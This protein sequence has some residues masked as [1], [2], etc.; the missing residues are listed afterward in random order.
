MLLAIVKNRYEESANLLAVA[1]VTANVSVTTSAGLQLG[2]G[3]ND[4]YAG[5][6][7]PFTA[8]VV[9]EENPTISYVPV[10]GVKYAQ[11]VFSPVPVSIL[12]RLTGSLADPTYVYNA[13]VSSVN[14]I[15]NPDFRFFPSDPD[16]HF[17]HFVALMTTLTQAQR[18]HWAEDPQQAASLAI[19]IDRY[20]PAHT[21]EVGELLNLLG[22]PKPKTRSARI[23]LPVY[24]ALDGRDS[25]GVGII[26]RSVGDLVEILSAAIEVPEGDQQKGIAKTYPPPAGAGSELSVRHSKTK[27]LHASVAVQYRDGW[28]YIDETDQA[29]KRFFRM[30]GALWSV[31]IADS[32][33]ETT[34]VPALT[35][36]VS[37]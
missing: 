4:N 33:S 23:A 17:S 32:A 31:T 5:N 20:A 8:G 21:V 11:Q 10:A 26:T 16:P 6:L 15:L 24:L 14:G 27:P 37:R 36:P 34:A 1:S 35:V 3:D 13:L 29:T 9:Y 30:M 2:F 12:A 25:G 18:L 22:L 19:V 7:V 28:F